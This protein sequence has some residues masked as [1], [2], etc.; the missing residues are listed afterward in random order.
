MP[1]VKLGNCLFGQKNAYG[2]AYFLCDHT[3]LKKYV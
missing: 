3:L 1:Y 2:L